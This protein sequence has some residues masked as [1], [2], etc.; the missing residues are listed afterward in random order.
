MHQCPAVFLFAIRKRI[1][2]VLWFL[3]VFL[4]GEHV[5][6]MGFASVNE[7]VDFVLDGSARVAGGDDA[8]IER[9]HV[10]CSCDELSIGF[11]LDDGINWC[12]VTPN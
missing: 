9:S 4:D 12:F 8:V 11:M 5:D 1:I 2:L 10:V 6:V 3:P 7:L